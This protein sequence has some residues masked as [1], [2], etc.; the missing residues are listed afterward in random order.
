[1]SEAKI[2]QVEWT[3]LRLLQ[4]NARATNKELATAAGIAESTCLERVRGLRNRGVIRGF[5]ADVDLTALGR[6]IR[7]IVTV[8]LHPKTLESVEEFQ[9][10]VLEEPE[11]L[12]VTTTTGADDFLVD[13]A[14]PDV[15][16]LRVF[17]LERLNGLDNV[18]DTRT[19]LVYGSRRKQIVEPL[20]R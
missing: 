16:H 14:V 3:I 9:V 10:G 12:G 20:D 19:A 18:V 7:A 8:R 11:V 4:K 13:V 5:H 6:P 1:M 17:V 2:T 15:D